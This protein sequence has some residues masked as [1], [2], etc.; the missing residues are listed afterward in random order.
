MK[1]NNVR[2]TLYLLTANG[3]VP[4]AMVNNGLPFLPIILF[5][6]RDDV[7]TKFMCA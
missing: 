1:I 6:L 3:S 7:T 2:G 5:F 4:V